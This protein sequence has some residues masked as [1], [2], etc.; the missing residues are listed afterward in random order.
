MKQQKLDLILYYEINNQICFEFIS[1]KSFKK[2]NKKV[3]V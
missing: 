3:D 2:V 1:E